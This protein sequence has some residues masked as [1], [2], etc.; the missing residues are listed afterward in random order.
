MKWFVNL[1][2]R[3]KLFLGFGFLIIL[4]VTVIVKAYTDIMAI[5]KSQKHLY[6]ED[7]TTAVDLMVLRTNLNGVRAG[8][9]TVIWVTER[10][11]LETWHQDVKDRTKEIDEKMQRLLERG[12]NVPRIASRA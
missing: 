12:Q 9:L 5:Q 1:S 4:L 6:N 3:A 11:D 7:F 10:S 8:L 2:T